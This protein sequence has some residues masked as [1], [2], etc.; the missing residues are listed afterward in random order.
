MLAEPLALVLVPLPPVSE[1]LPPVPL[2]ALLPLML[3][4]VPL[5]P[6]AAVK[7]IVGVA[8]LKVMLPDDWMV[9]PEL[10]GWMTVPL[11]DQ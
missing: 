2:P 4:E 5:V 6:P 1:T 3:R 11:R 7:P 8:P 10:A 9:S